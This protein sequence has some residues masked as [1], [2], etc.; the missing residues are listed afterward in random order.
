MLQY[1]E[2]K[3]SWE[4][5]DLAHVK[6]K[7]A[8]ELHIRESE[9]QD[10]VIVKRSLDARQ[11]PEL[12]M[13]YTVRFSA[14]EEERIWRRNKKNRNLS[15]VDPEPGVLDRVSELSSDEK[16]YI[17]GAGP[18]G[19]FCAYYLC[20]CGCRPVLLERGA[21]VEERAEDVKKFWEEGI[22]D[23]ESNV[24]FG[25][26]G[27]GTFSDGKLNTGVKDK[28]GKKQFVLNS[29]VWF[30]A[31][32][33]IL[34]D[35][36]PHLGTDVLFQVIRNMRK[37][38]IRLG[39]TFMFHTRLSGIETEDGALRGVRVIS[40]NDGAERILPCDR[41]VLAI[42]H[43]ARDTFSMLH[44]A[45][46]AMTPKAF[47]V[48]VRVQHDQADIDRAQYG[49]TDPELPAASYKCTGTTGDG[50]GVYSFCMCPGG[51]VV[52]AST[53]PGGLAVNGM[54]DAARN[55]GN[56]NSAIVVSV[57]P[58]DFGG[59]GPLA[60][61]E[62]QRKWEKEMAGLCP[63]KIPVQRYGD[64]VRNQETEKPGH[65]K[66]CVKGRWQYGNLRK[67]LPNFVQDGIIEG[68][69]QF[70]KRIAGFAGEDVLLLGIET[71][72]S[73]PVRI[74]RDDDLASLSVRGMYPCGEGAG[75]AGG[76]MSAAMDG[77][78]VAMKI[79]ETLQEKHHA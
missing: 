66:P 5:R 47:A 42:G 16:I 19:L 12:L 59:E 15:L 50:R 20:L 39:C 26:G 53:E 24:S 46:V 28:T 33:E 37:E 51:Y 49:K 57:A 11:K 25:E 74:E 78:R 67:A 21:P 54:S 2:C 32:E 1:S 75:Y 60:G 36:R 29:F 23:P 65:I 56:A 34:Y 6:K 70:D 61:V 8:H 35:S 31:P 41:L 77:L 27:A 38:M 17:A 43:S 63:G 40:G 48:G 79:Q 13:S 44:G 76:I 68:M 30:G 55:S 45:G 9:M 3:V 62:F 58:A 22:L 73:S 7:V 18:A 69:E 4:N 14:L 71:R 10:F 52:N 64:F 72:T